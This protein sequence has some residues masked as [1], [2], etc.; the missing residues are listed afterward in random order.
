MTNSTFACPTLDD[1]LYQADCLH[2]AYGYNYQYLGNGRND[3]N[4]ARWDNF[5][6]PFHRIKSVSNTIVVADSRGA[7]DPHGRHSYTLDPPRLAVEFGATRFGPT[8]TPHTGDSGG[9]DVG[10]GLSTE[11]FGYSPAEARH[12]RKA[13][14]VFVDGHGEAMALLEF[15]YQLSDGS[16][17][18]LRKDTPVPIREPNTGTYTANNRRFNGEG[19]DPIAE[20]HRPGGVP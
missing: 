18:G 16:T 17:P 1:P 13:N 8:A 15:G 4:P 19:S 9:G 10:P 2:G 14:A 3:N 11:I 20:K 12:K 6:V 5:P 7:G